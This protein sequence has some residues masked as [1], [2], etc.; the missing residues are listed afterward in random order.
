[1]RLRAMVLLSCATL[2]A[3][4]EPPRRK[5]PL[6]EAP[7]LI[8]VSHQTLSTATGRGPESELD[9]LRQAL[10]EQQRLFDQ[11]RRALDAQQDSLRTM[12]ARIDQLAGKAAPPPVAA[13]TPPRPVGEAPEKPK[14]PDLPRISDTVGG[15][16]TPKGKVVLEPS[17]EYDYAGNNRVF[18]DAFTF[19]PAIAVGLIDVRQI[20]RHTVI[21]A[22]TARVG[23]TDFFELSGRVPFLYREDRQ[24]SR[25]VAIG[26]G[27]DETFTADGAGLGDLEFSGRYQL[28]TGSGGWPVFIANLSASIPTGT[29]PYAI[30]LVNAQGVPG[31]RFPTELPTGVGY[32]SAQPA[33]TLL[34]PTDPAVLYASLSYSY[35][36]ETHESV[37]KIDPGDTVG[38]N[39]GMGFGVNERTSFSLGYSH[40]HVFGTRVN[41]QTLGGSDLN[42]GEFLLGYA[43]KFTK[44][45]SLNLSLSI[46]ATP[47]SQNVKLT[48]RL[49]TYFD[50]F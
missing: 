17:V 32:Y 36:A 34:Y 12:Q 13:A 48:F 29:S 28:N 4:A 47:D 24:R 16:L 2:T 19:L 1:M 43:Y 33:L 45:V 26:A 21:G 41:G 25:P 39:F 9:Q 42:I 46:G 23:I 3:C 35:N 6:L 14:T 22:A 38:G 27:I 44:D 8:A 20:Q 40:K 37:G 31:A 15:V 49:P 30:P 50:V 7:P 5:S 10:A 18:L 11:Q